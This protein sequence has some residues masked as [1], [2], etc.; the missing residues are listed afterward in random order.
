MLI[1]VERAMRITVLPT[2]VSGW[3]ALIRLFLSANA[4]MDAPGASSLQSAE[5]G[6]NRSQSPV[7]SSF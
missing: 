6:M 7:Q 1:R 5:T 3:S 4:T 2:H